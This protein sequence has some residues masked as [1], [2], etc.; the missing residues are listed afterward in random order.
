MPNSAGSVIS[1]DDG[2]HSAMTLTA[3][4]NH[5]SLLLLNRVLMYKLPERRL[6]FEV[7]ILKHLPLIVRNRRK[8]GGGGNLAATPATIQPQATTASKDGA[9]IHH[10]II[11]LKAEIA[12]LRHHIHFIVREL[13]MATSAI[14]FLQ[15]ISN[16]KDERIK[17]AESRVKKLEAVITEK[18]N[19]LKK[20]SCIFAQFHETTAEN[21]HDEPS[22]DFRI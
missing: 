20:F 7:N 10:R 16:M 18:D 1:G 19:L 8:S 21:S 15:R 3:E 6:L 4:M 9:M 2:K 17:A 13:D 12:D 5:E 11:S 22:L 14:H